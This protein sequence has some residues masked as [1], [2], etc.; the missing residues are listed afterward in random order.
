VATVIDLDDLTSSD[1]EHLLHLKRDREREAE[2]LRIATLLSPGSA[3]A[4]ETERVAAQADPTTKA[5]L[6]S[7]FQRRAGWLKP[8]RPIRYGGWPLPIPQCD[9]IRPWEPV[10]LVIAAI[11]MSEDGVA[12]D[13]AQPVLAQ[14]A[15]TH[16]LGA[17]GLED[18]LVAFREA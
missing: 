3:W 7:H 14:L 12:D 11:N 9:R 16:G 8:Q 4:T 5:V 1:L 2:D 18:A 15:A 6:E 10:D 13:V 17:T